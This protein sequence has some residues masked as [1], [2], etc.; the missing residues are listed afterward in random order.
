MNGNVSSDPKEDTVVAGDASGGE[1]REAEEQV[2]RKSE[3]KAPK[4]WSNLKK[5][6]LLQRFIRELEKVRKFNP[7]KPHLLPLNPDPEAEKVNLRP[8]TLDGR[9]SAEEWMLDH[10]LRQAVSQLAPTQKK[11]VALLVRAFETVVPPQE[12]SQVQFRVPR[13]RNSSLA[14]ML[15]RDDRVV[16]ISDSANQEMSAQMVK[17]TEKAYKD[18]GDCESSLTFQGS[19]D[20]RNE[21]IKLEDPDHEKG[22]LISKARSLSLDVDGM[23]VPAETSPG[24]DFL[25]EATKAEN[26]MADVT[27]TEAI[28]KEQLGLQDEISDSMEG[29]V[30]DGSQS[31]QMDRRN[32]IKMW[33]MI[34]QHVVSGIAEK[35]GLGLLEG[36]EDDEAEDDMS[37][38]TS[39]GDHAIASDLSQTSN[40]LR[41]ETHVASNLRSGLT[42]SDALKL[43]KEAVDEILLPEVQ[44]DASDTQSV[45]VPDQDI[46]ERNVKAEALISKKSD[47]S[48]S[49]NWSKLKRLMLLKR[50]IK[51]LEKARDFK[52]KPH[53]LLP[54]NPDPEPEKVDL[55]QQMMD[56]RKKAEQWMLDYAVQ[57]IVTKLTPARK[58]KV[59]MLV[60]AFE[61]V[62]P[63]PEI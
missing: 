36:G 55:R 35:V 34:Y 30:K 17:E 28:P 2:V 43:V 56:E 31:N 14:A 16:S 8:Q 26:A 47:L 1:I 61:A 45:T 44:D 12:D 20:A 3:K 13:L 37:S 15:A 59:F 18:K 50:S 7:R 41:E 9:K 29:E 33:H 48:K 38:A 11:K 51:A 19:T 39:N 40:D 53:Q 27:E 60:E 58:R 6:I 54:Q 57:H 32:H 21:N 24:P 5:W 25:P 4:H 52:P 62:V 46:P 23:L 10:A 42:K 49:K 22:E 63:F